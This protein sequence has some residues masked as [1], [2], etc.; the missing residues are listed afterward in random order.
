MFIFSSKPLVALCFYYFIKYAVLLKNQGKYVGV[1]WHQPKSSAL[2]YECRKP[3]LPH[4][5]S[6]VQQISEPNLFIGLFAN[7]RSSKFMSRR[8]PQMWLGKNCYGLIHSVY[9]EHKLSP[10]PC[11][12]VLCSIV[13]S[14]ICFYFVYYVHDS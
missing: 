9:T 4:K 2:I 10:L 8:P 11:L 13:F 1:L 6:H 14:Q 12:E 3:M 7:Q 5:A